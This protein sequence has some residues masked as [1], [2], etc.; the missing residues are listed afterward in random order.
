V[1]LIGTQTTNFET[2]QNAA[3]AP[4]PQTW[5]FPTSAIL[6]TSGDAYAKSNGF[7]YVYGSKAV[8]TVDELNGGQ[9]RSLSMVVYDYPV[10]AVYTFEEVNG[11]KTPIAPATVVTVPQAGLALGGIAPSD[12]GLV[13]VSPVPAGLALGASPVS[14]GL[15]SDIIIGAPLAGLA[16]GG[17][18]PAFVITSSL[19]IEAQ[20]GLML[21]STVPE[22]A[23]QTYLV[24]VS[25]RDNFLHPIVAPVEELEVV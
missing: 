16:L 10:E 20:S 24:D 12:L 18:L 8:Y 13:T 19:S 4:T 25:C 17:T 1:A 3:R 15:E 22:F 6:A 23:G 5:T 14:L 9:A 2:G 11:F 21:C 7:A